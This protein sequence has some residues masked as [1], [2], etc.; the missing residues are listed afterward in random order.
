[1]QWAQRE[2]GALPPRPDA[3]KGFAGT[4]LQLC[5]NSL[6]TLPL[7]DLDKHLPFLDVVFLCLVIVFCGAWPQPQGLVHAGQVSAH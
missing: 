4:L 7:G 5:L 3:I 6:A 1:M 2:E